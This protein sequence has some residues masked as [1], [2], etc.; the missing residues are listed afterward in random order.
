MR[1]RI[2]KT[3]SSYITFIT[4]SID[5]YQMDDIHVDQQRWYQRMHNIYDDHR[6]ELEV[7]TRL[8]ES[9]YEDVVLMIRRKELKVILEPSKPI[10]RRAHST[11]RTYFRLV[12]IDWLSEIK[13]QSD[14]FLQLLRDDW[15]T[16]I[17]IR[18]EIINKKK[19]ILTSYITS[20]N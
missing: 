9:D 18:F 7:V 13:H 20:I 4:A 15:W 16:V 2:K 3:N 10:Y 19:I 14:R 5:L 12:D 1:E 8:S 17:R 6:K 11:Y